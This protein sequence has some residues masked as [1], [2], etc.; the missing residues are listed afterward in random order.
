VIYDCGTN[1]RI[2]VLFQATCSEYRQPIPITKESQEENSSYLLMV[3][4]ASIFLPS[5]LL[6]SAD[7]KL[8]T[9]YCEKRVA[10]VFGKPHGRLT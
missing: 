7:N 3:G 10:S 8:D 4:E 2:L 9:G 1:D 5:R 6:Y